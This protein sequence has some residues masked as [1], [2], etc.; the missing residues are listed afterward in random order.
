MSIKSLNILLRS[1]AIG[2]LLDL[3]H[4]VVH[5]LLVLEVDG[6]AGEDRVLQH[7]HLA[8]LRVHLLAALPDILDLLGADM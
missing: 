3:G 4:E 2:Q 1:D 7:L 6:G 5:L 8:H